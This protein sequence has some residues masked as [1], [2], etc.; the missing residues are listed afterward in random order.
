MRTRLWMRTT[1]AAGC[2][3]AAAAPAA[4][5]TIDF[6]NAN[7]G[8]GPVVLNAPYSGE[9]VT[10]VR[11]ILY[12][13]TR[14]ERTVT[15]TIHRDSAGRVRREQSIFGLAAL[16]APQDSAQVVTIVD[17]VNNM[18]W[19][20]TTADKTARGMRGR[21]KAGGRPG[22]GMM[23]PPPPP[24]PPPG[25]GT[26][27]RPGAPP[28]PPPAPGPGTNSMRIVPLGTKTIEGLAATGTKSTMTF[29]AGA[30][31]NDR[32]IEVTEE[33][34]ES[35]DLRV[36]LYSRRHDPRTGDVEYRLTK[37]TRDEPAADLFAVPSDY[38]VVD[39]PS[40]PPPPPPPPPPGAEN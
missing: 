16:D 36:L 14:I 13:G 32:P 33:R 22:A 5:Q 20:L 30:M 15:A 8:G 11:Q 25:V 19:S 35:T 40:P 12:D 6:L 17:P 21:V 27:A 39:P 1:L 4:A 18:I 29:P 9:G 34:W 10:T 7:A 23:P 37:V 31:G 26:A 24:P 2:I 38:R 3:T 28:I